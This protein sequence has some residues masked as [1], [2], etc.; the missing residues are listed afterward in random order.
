M[1]RQT[2]HDV[3]VVGGGGAVWPIE[4]ALGRDVVLLEKNP[5]LGGSTAW[6]VGWVTAS[7]TLHQARNKGVY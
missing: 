2:V 4:A 6:S 5:R 3:V 7:N 1:T